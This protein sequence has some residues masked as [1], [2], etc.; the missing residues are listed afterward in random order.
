M[1]VYARM[2]PARIAGFEELLHASPGLARR[3][4][5]SL[6]SCCSLTSESILIVISAINFTFLCFSVINTIPTK[7][8]RA[9]AKAEAESEELDDK[10]F[11]M[12]QWPQTPASPQFPLSPTTPR[13]RAFQTLDGSRGFQTLNGTLAASR[14]PNR[15]LPLRQ[16]ISMGEK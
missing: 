1:D 15:D 6:V 5:V 9:H 14:G 2:R 12:G 10:R 11:E 13:T 3:C 4:C 8:Q 16:H 7:E